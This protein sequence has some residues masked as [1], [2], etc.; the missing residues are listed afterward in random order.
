MLSADLVDRLGAIDTPTICNALELVIPAR[1]TTGFNRRPLVCPFPHLKPIVGYA[2]TA[3]IRSREPNPS[4]ESRATR[5]A[6]Y[7][8]IE[9]GP[10]PSIAVIQDIDTTDRGIG[11]FW[12]EVQT[13]VHQALGCH[14]VVTDGSV[15]DTDQM[16]K[17]FF[18]LAGSIM[19]S[20]VHA[21]IVDFNRAVTVAG[22]L[23][24]PG[25]IVHADHHGAVVVP[26]DVAARVPDAVD[27]LVRREK[28]M[29]DACRAPDFSS[30]TIRAAFERM[31][32]IH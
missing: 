8:Y 15:R 10:R 30:A 2:R 27:L 7:E 13:N 1:R 21:D 25:D 24:S 31:N 14:G 4:G 3:T 28:V 23:V 32:E 5:I 16:A 19:P 29:L 11:A 6:Y 22:M 18:V 20:H 17:G 9:K 26:A 12:G